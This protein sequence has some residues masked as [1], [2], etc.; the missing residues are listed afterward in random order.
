ME[1]QQPAP[2]PLLARAAILRRFD[3]AL[4]RVALD[5]PAELAAA[6]VGSADVEATG[7][8]A[9][10]L[11]PAAAARAAAQLRAGDPA[12]EIVIHQRAFR[13]YLGRL[14]E[15]APPG[16]PPLDEDACFYHFDALYML[17]GAQEQWPLI[18]A[19]AAELRAAPLAQERHRQRLEMVEGYG[20]I[21][22]LE[23]A[24]GTAILRRLL[25][26]PIIDQ[27]VELKARKG[28][29]DGAW[30]QARYA[31]AIAGYEQLLDAAARVGDLPYQGLALMNMSL[32]RQELGQSEVALAD[33]ERSLALFRAAGDRQREGYALHHAALH[34]LYV[35]RWDAA[36]GYSAAAR[37]QFERLGLTNYLGF[38]AWVQGYLA[39]ILDETA[40]AEAAYRQALALAEQREHPQLTL[41]ADTLLHLGLL[42]HSQ[43]QL[44]RALEHYDRAL[45][46]ATRL[47]RL[48]QISLLHF[49]RGQVF[50]RMGRPGKAFLTYRTA[51]G[52]VERMGGS[53][54]REDV[55][56]SLLGTT[57]QIYEALV[58]L[59]ME[60]Y[61]R[62]GKGRWIAQAVGYVEQ[63]RS[64]AF[65]DALAR[66]AADQ[67]PVADTIAAQVGAPLA[68]P[69]IQQSLPADALLIEYFTTGVQPRGEQLLARLPP[70]NRRLRELLLLPPRIIGFAI[71]RDRCAPFA[72]TLDPNR[73]RPLLG[74]R[75]PGRHLLLGPLPVTLYTQLI[76]PAAALLAGKRMLYLVPHGPLHYVP[77]AALRTT[78]GEYLLGLSV[79]GDAGGLALAQ[80]PSATILVR[81]GLQGRTAHGTAALAIGFND[82]GGAQP[83]RFAEAE[84][85]HIA[86]LL[87]GSAWT[88]AQPKG[89]DL[90]RAGATL[91]HLHIAGHALFTPG[92]PLGS[93]LL[94]GDGDALS[95]REIISSV[96]LGAELVTLSS[97]TSGISHVVPGDE[98]LGLP[99]ALLLAGAPTIVCARWEAVDLVA[100][101]IMDRFYTEI[102]RHPPAVAL[103]NAQ[104]AVRT[105]TFAELEQTFARWRGAGGALAAAIGATDQL[106][107]ELARTVRAA[108]AADDAEGDAGGP[109]EAAPPDPQSRPFA[110]PL[111]WAP[112]MV[113]GRG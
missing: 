11:R 74:D 75:H 57:Q 56:I 3:P 101:L 8:G 103:R 51:I 35:G 79:A 17:L 28:L 98:L 15:P 16:R 25:Q 93:W 52:Y 95:A 33:C 47:E 102:P 34:S 21:Y 23:I 9:F 112:F 30:Y 99:R 94:L 96:D 27:D 68:L 26:G 18:M 110:A 6:F 54:T 111:L 100:L 113:I 63:A 14:G 19:Y 81:G 109:V 13:Y 106:L 77:F 38:V 5:C 42:Y 41:A 92:D 32:V 43:G 84:A 73:L 78:D 24:H 45:S 65:L 1:H 64:R 88:G 72:A 70:A 83:L 22:L 7:D 58:L 90:R 50:E 86:G 29:A 85:A 80:A 62:A 49:R 4:L 46:Y 89:A 108:L 104:V 44:Q 107:T 31:E 67:P 12:E 39:D 76:A 97:C 37:E 48:H 71:S 87:A 91:R 36:R 60:F 66:K 61:G 10:R 53:T 105:M 59:C 55:K 2:L 20:A 69:A 82:A 40:E